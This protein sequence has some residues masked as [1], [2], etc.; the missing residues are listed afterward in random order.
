MHSKLV[1][2]S[3]LGLSDVGETIMTVDSYRIR[4]KII[5]NNVKRNQFMRVITGHLV[6]EI[7]SEQ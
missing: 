5:S 1:V 4:L 3:K 7:P 2:L 6:E